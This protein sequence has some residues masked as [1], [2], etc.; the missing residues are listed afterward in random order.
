MEWLYQWIGQALCSSSNKDM[1]DLH[2]HGVQEGCIRRRR[3]VIRQSRQG[4]TVILQ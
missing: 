4:L 1:L 3:L 2:L